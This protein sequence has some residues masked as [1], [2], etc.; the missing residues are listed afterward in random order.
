MPRWLLEWYHALGIVILEAYGISENIVPVSMNSPHVFRFGTVGR[1]LAGNDIVIAEDGELLVKGTGVCSGYYRDESGVTPLTANGYLA[2]GDYAEEDD[3]GFISLTGRK[4][5]IFKTS[6][7]RRIAPVGIESVLLKVPYVEHAVVFG[8]QR[9]FLIGILVVS[10]ELLSKQA[11]R[12]E[13]AALDG[14]PS[15]S[16]PPCET[17]KSDLTKELASLPHYQRPAGILVTPH[18]FTVQGSE[19]TSN[20][21]VRRKV[22]EQKY[23]ADIERLYE[24]LD[25]SSGTGE[26]VVWAL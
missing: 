8:A 4:S 21:K 2:T 3:D 23:A 11:G 25:E 5:E 14:N 7:G 26:I 12:G 19:L 20:L 24:A 17:I 1:P 18:P 13:G 15:L 10:D 16:A 6:T 9:K 22:I